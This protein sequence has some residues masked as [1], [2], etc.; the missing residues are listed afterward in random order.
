MLA[1]V[2]Q[3]LTCRAVQQL[4]RVRLADFLEVG[5]HRDP[6]AR[7]ELPQQF[8]YRR[9][10]PE[11]GEHLRVQFGDRRAQRRRRV[12][13]RGVDRVEFGPGGPLPDLV[14]LQPGRQQRLQ[15]TV[16]QPFG[17]FPVVPLVGL[18]GL[19]H[20][21]AAHLLQGLHPLL[22]THEHEAQHGGGHRQP[23]EEPEVRVDHVR[24]AHAVVVLGV[25]DPHRQI[26][27]GRQ[28]ADGRGH[29][30]TVLKGHRD[31]QQEE[32][33]QQC[34][35]RATGHQTQRQ[36]HHQVDAGRRPVRPARHGSAQHRHQP[37]HR[38]D[39]VQ[40]QDHGIQ[41]G[42]PVVD[43]PDPD[44]DTDQRDQREP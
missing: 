37:D 26:A 28:G 41:L 5:P 20:Q 33:G 9:R 38:G 29:Q 24:Q 43:L 15:R 4:L 22:A 39:G 19:G 40:A 35:G 13:Q 32:D 21:L 3:Q 7:L 6:A 44:Q 10:Q 1:D 23:H 31:R 27:R 8:P 16:V 11:L 42:Q 17:D 36:D 25:E 14:E 34:R 18:H 30:R 12:F 2:G